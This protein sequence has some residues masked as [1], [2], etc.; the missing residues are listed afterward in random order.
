MTVPKTPLPW[1]SA[2][3]ALDAYD[4]EC[5]EI[6]ASGDVPDESVIDRL[7]AHAAIDMAGEAARITFPDRS[8]LVGHCGNWGEPPDDWEV[9]E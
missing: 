4:A 5:D 2:Q 1:T 7:M 6:A 3:E 8:V 9:E